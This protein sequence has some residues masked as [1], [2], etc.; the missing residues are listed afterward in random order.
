MSLRTSLLVAA[1]ALV[2]A[3]GPREV[4]VAELPPNLDGGFEPHH[5]CTTNAECP[6]DA[7]CER[8]SCDALAGSCRRMPLF[9]C[10][11]DASPV[12]GCD[13]V[14]YWND[15][16]R[17]QHGMSALASG[18]CSVSAVC[19]TGGISCPMSDAVCARMLPSA[20]TCPSTTMQGTCWVLPTQCPATV[21]GDAS[22]IPCG[23]AA[24]T[25][26]CGALRSEQPHRRATSC[27]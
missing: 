7:F 4:V 22:W 20:A 23:G 13:G 10:P 5:P 3:C 8:T 11:N 17:A 15:C 14:T 25:T 19:G 27:P 2:A 1:L 6:P 18:E 26:T 24:C 16:L 21:S 9:E 12:C